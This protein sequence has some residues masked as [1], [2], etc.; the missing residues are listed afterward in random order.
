GS[1]RYIA[2]RCGASAPQCGH[3]VANAS[4]STVLPR[5]EARLTSS[6]A[7]VRSRN[8]GA[9]E[10]TGSSPLA[11]AGLAAE[12]ELRSTLS[13]PA[14]EWNPTS[15]AALRSDGEAL[16]SAAGMVVV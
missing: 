7:G 15:S 1:D 11:A 10:P 16:R 5:S 2:L 12:I 3:Q 6:P 8:P 9:L 14:V 13:G 4:R